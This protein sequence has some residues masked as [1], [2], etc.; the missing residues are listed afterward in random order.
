MCKTLFLLLSLVSVSCFAGVANAELLVE[1]TF[2]NN[3]KDPSGNHRDGIAVGNPIVLGGQLQLDGLSFVDIPLADANPF[4]GSKDFSIEMSFKTSHP[5]VLI[6]SARDERPEN[7]SMSVYISD[8]T[9]VEL[10]RGCVVYD[11]FW[12]DSIANR[13]N[14][15]DGEWH[16]LAVIYTAKFNAINIYVEGVISSSGSIKPDI[17]N[18]AYDTVRIGGSMNHVFTTETSANFNGLIDNIRI[19]SHA[20]GGDKVTASYFGA[21]K[22]PEIAEHSEKLLRKA[23]EKLGEFGSW[24]TNWDARTKHAN[25]IASA[26]LLIARVKEAKGHPIKEILDEYYEVAEQ[27]PDSSSA[28]EALCKIDILDKKNAPEYE[29][30]RSNIML[31]RNHVAKSDYANSRKYIKLFIDKYIRAKDDL[32]LLGQL[33]SSN[34]STKNH[35]E[36]YKI[37]I[38]ETISRDPNLEITCAIFRYVA[39]SFYRE[40]NRGQLWEL[41]QQ[42]QSNF[43]ETKLATCA[44]AVLADKHYQKGNYVFAL[45][46]FEPELFTQR[47]PEAEI[48]S[49]IDTVIAVYRA[50]TLRVQGVDTSKIYKA[51]ADYNF[52]Q[53][54]NEVA[55]HCYKQS[56]KA[57]GR[58]LEVFQAAAPK[59]INYCNSTPDA[60]VW[61]WRGLFAAYDDDL[62]TGAVI[63]ERFLDQDETSILS[64]RAYYDIARARMVSSKYS[65]A[66]E[67]ITKA[68]KISPCKPVIELE[69]ELNDA[70]GI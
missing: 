56:A 20:L 12:V 58:G 36:L 14:W 18:I 60:E 70:A 26:L 3:L 29:E 27:F 25:E 8:G 48:V 46:A 15:M 65:E 7:Q 67:A 50:N 35:E 32:R 5:G 53:G 62:N 47:Y 66:K 55:I 37:I 44:A 17:P 9:D 21:I 33:T 4:D 40:K 6:S 45:Q 2:E 43:P 64:A 69:S 10:P 13:T 22:D 31:I 57:R 30:A 34:G 38:E 68:K 23:H 61:F 51:V 24:R 1:Y 42:I 54:R 28:F 52:N 19:Y 11:N 41:A 16:H 63:Y 59:A 39:L 49:N